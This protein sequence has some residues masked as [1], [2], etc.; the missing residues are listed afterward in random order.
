MMDLELIEK[1]V[2]QWAVILEFQRTKRVSHALDGVRLTMGKIVRRINAP[3]VTRAMM[4]GA[5]NPVH[6]RVAH[7]DIWRCHIDLGAERS[8]SIRELS[9]T[10]APK[11]IEI[12]LD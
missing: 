2:I 6:D 5:H 11:Q 10:H 9:R 1:P 7:I 4:R 3:L 8:T 12:F